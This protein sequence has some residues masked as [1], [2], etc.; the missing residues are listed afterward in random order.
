MSL[1]IGTL[2]WAAAVALLVGYRLVTV[3]RVRGDSASYLLL[4]LFGSIG[5][6][7]STAVA[8][9]W[10]SAAVNVIW[11][12]LGICP[13]GRALRRRQRYRRQRCGRQRCRRLRRH[14]LRAQRP[15]MRRGPVSARAVGGATQARTPVT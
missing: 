7:V 11:L 8:H 14:R 10:P 4:N 12:G 3:G 13:L 1:A 5:L 2:G 15:R 9:A 6:G